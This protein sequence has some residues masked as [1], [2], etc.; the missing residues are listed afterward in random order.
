MENE[1]FQTVVVQVEFGLTSEWARYPSLCFSEAINFRKHI[2][3]YNI[4]IRKIY[5]YAPHIRNGLKGTQVN[6]FLYIIVYYTL[7]L[8]QIHMF[9]Y[10]SQ[11]S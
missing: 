8:Q 1:N 11:V 4:C 3:I 5:T 7:V 6:V 10:I 2:Y 9:L